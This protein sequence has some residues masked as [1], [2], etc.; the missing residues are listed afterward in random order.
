MVPR[1]KIIRGCKICNVCGKNKRVSSYDKCHTISGIRGECT[2]CR[3]SSDRKAKSRTVSKEKQRQYNIKKIHG[4]SPERY[5]ILWDSQEGLCAICKVQLSSLS[6]KAVH[7]DHCHATGKVRGVLCNQCN[8]GLGHFRDS[9][10]Y[11]D[12]AKQYLTGAK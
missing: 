4:L 9:V 1:H 10:L 2:E 8:W 3:R 11:L 5:K 7:I 12:A 6:R